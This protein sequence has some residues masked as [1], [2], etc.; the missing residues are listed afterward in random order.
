MTFTLWKCEE[1]WGKWDNV[2]KGSNIWW[3]ETTCR[4]KGR[5][6]RKCEG[7]GCSVSMRKR[8]V[9]WESVG[10]RDAVWEKRN[11]CEKEGRSLRKELIIKWQEK[12]KRLIRNKVS[13]SWLAI[14]FSKRRKSPN[15]SASQ[16]APRTVDSNFANAIYISKTWLKSWT[17]ILWTAF[18]TREDWNLSS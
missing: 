18:E 4:K 10:K 8:D 16:T 1:V 6:V 14:D 12:N 5:L 2:E 9:L 11:S 17:N 13:L 3:W 7:K 15:S